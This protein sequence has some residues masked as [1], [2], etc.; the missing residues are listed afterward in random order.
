MAIYLDEQ[1]RPAL[2]RIIKKWRE[3]HPKDFVA[4]RIQKALDSDLKRLDGIAS[5]EHRRGKYI[6]EQNCCIKC[7]S[8]YEPGMGQHFTLQVN[9]SS[10]DRESNLVVSPHREEP[11]HHEA[12]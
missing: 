6:G 8:Y 2:T 10:S 5:C 11:D 1:T 4:D 9:V 7:G 3:E 12:R